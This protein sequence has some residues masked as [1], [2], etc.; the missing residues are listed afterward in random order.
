MTILSVPGAELSY[1]VAGSGPLL[2][3]IPGGAMPSDAYIGLQAAL[4]DRFTVVRFDGRGL[5]QSR[6]TG[7]PHAITVSGQADD[8]LALLD[9]RSPDAPAFVFGSSGG[10][11][12]GLDLVTRYPERVRRL[13]AHEPPLTYLLDEPG[14]AAEDDRIMQVY[15]EQGVMAAMAAFLGSTGLDDE[16]QAAPPPDPEFLQQLASNFDVFFA[17]MWAGIGAFRMDVEALLSRPVVLGVGESSDQSAER[18]ARELARLLGRGPVTFVGG[19]TGFAE[20]PL[21]FA[22]EL[23]PLLV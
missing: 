18:A 4:A 19:H 16:Q 6:F 12:T 21:R 10:A 14:E 8:A 2:L 1:D 3:L 15:R 9:A 5:G 17:H 11:L 20:D 13:I 22:K 23:A 7:E